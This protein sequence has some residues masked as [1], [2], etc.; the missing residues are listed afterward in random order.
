MLYMI[1][2]CRKF[3]HFLLIIMCNLSSIMLNC[4]STY[5]KCKLI[6][7][8]MKN[9]S[10]HSN[11][12]ERCPK[13]FSL[14]NKHG[15]Q[16]IVCGMTNWSAPFAN[17]IQRSLLLL[18]I[19]FLFLIIFLYCPWSRLLVYCLRSFFLLVHD[20]FL[21]I[22]HDFSSSSCSQVISFLSSSHPCSWSFFSSL[23][24][25]R[26]S[27]SSSFD[28]SSS[29]LLVHKVFFLLVDNLLFFFFFF[30]HKCSLQNFCEISIVG[31]LCCQYAL[32][33]TLGTMVWTL[34]VSRSRV[35]N[36]ETFLKII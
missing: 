20:L 12:M 18:L 6:P 16:Q 36:C 3:W 5:S 22:V 27:Y 34:I 15:V 9:N 32:P 8:L 33:W 10:N 2:R 28:C 4:H 23:S 7:H 21:L 17:T 30:F 35:F 19:F 29:F 25:P 26:S 13:S 11:I 14:V 1:I 31:R 24:Y